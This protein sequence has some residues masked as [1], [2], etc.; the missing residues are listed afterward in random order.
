MWIVKDSKGWVWNTC[1]SEEVARDYVQFL[2]C[3]YPSE[4]FEIVCRVEFDD[5]LGI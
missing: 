2:E 5:G 1:P 3:M 4:V